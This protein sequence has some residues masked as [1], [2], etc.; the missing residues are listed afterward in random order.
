MNISDKLSPAVKQ[1][2]PS[3]IR[4]FFDLVMA[5]E[6]VISLGV[7][8]PDFVTP[9]HIRENTIYSL[10]KGMTSYTSNAGLY[11]LREAICQYTEERFSI[12]YSPE[13][14][15][16]VTVGA[17]E[18]ID[19]ALRTLVT[20]GDEVLVVEPSY[21]SYAPCATLAGAIPVSV[22][23]Y[24]KD[25]FKLM[26]DVL[27]S[28][29]T[30][31]SKILMMCFPNNPTGAVMERCDLQKIADIV[32]KHDLIVLSD[33]VYAELS[34]DKPHRSIAELEGMKDRTIVFGG[35]S[36][37]FAMTGW[38]IG[39]AMGHHEIIAAMLK[40]HQYTILCA[41]IMGQVA[42]LEALKNGYQEMQ[43]MVEQY[44]RRRKLIVKGFQEMGLSCH[45]P[46]GA[47]YAFP[48]IEATGYTDYEFAEQLLKQTKVA[49]VPGSVFGQGGAG[50]IRCS[51]ATSYAQI[52]EAVDRIAQF[53]QTINKVKK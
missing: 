51:Y 38:R 49:V 32:K 52:S 23:T 16:M 1:I 39:Y 20:P 33:E 29:I 24:Q 34:Y 26:P 19:I 28:K 43:M 13:Q 7:G 25:D 9:W 50:F 22:P 15:V 36:K 6:G 44:N 48:N 21:V 5:M 10:E 4:K 27:E 17:S 53:V 14:E 12:K 37:S 3:G 47:F 11:E 42:A 31:K 45:T 18:A 46:K 30:P 8:E 35:M 2:P 41:P 40:I